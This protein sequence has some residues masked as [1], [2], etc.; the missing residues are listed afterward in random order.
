MIT[1]RPQPRRRCLM[2]CEVVRQDQGPTLARTPMLMRCAW[3]TGEG[4]VESCSAENETV[5]FPGRVTGGEGSFGL[6]WTGHGPTMCRPQAGARAFVT[7]RVSFP[8][9][10]RGNQPVPYKACAQPLVVSDSWR[11]HGLQPAS[12]LCPWH[13]PGKNIGV[14]CHFLLQHGVID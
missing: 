4:W 2:Q 7:C 5:C 9:S 12:F 1:P 10:K 13:F 14:G 11:P 3:L 8:G 6:R